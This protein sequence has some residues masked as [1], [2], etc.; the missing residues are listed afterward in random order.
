MRETRW[1]NVRVDHER[2]VERFSAKRVCLPPIRAAISLVAHAEKR[3]TKA[4]RNL[5]DY[6]LSYSPSKPFRCGRL[7]PYS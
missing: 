5:P 6:K 3:L 4:E 1:L 7:P 2:T